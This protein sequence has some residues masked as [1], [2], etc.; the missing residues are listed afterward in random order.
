VHQYRLWRRKIGLSM[1][2]DYDHDFNKI[3]I[4]IYYPM[5][6]DFSNNM[7]KQNIHK[8][9]IVYIKQRNE[10]NT[11]FCIRYVHFEF[12]VMPFGL[13]NALISFW[14]VMK[15]IFNKFLNDFGIHGYLFKWHLDIFKKLKRT[16][17][18]YTPCLQQTLGEKNI[19]KIGKMCFSSIK[20]QIFGLYHL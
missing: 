11:T 9:N 16:W 3:T 5:I 18:T 12:N 4:K 1:C 14:H 7:I 17:K 2:V 19:C 10:W 6:Q 13:T 8:I 15:D 20:R